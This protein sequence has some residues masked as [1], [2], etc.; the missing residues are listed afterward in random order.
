MNLRQRAE[1]SKPQEQ[2]W[3]RNDAESGGEDGKEPG[4]ST[5]AGHSPKKEGYWVP[6]ATFEGRQEMESRQV[7]DS[8]RQLTSH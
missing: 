6:A 1:D 7:A 3:Q 4:G 8:D 5:L 2:G